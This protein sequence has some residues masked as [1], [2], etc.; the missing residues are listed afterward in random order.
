MPVNKPGLKG[1]VNV[2]RK[3]VAL[4]G[5]SPVTSDFF[6]PEQRLPLVVRPSES[7]LS[8]VGWARPNRE[9]IESRLAEHGAILFRDFGMQTAAD[10]EAFIRALSMEPVQYQEATSPRTHLGGNIYTSTDYP[11]AERI[12]WHN[13]N[14]HASSWPLH[15]FF[16]CETPATQG[17]ETPIADS[18]KIY[19][20]I[21]EPLRERFA[22]K[23][24]MY[25]RNFGDGLGLPWQSVFHTTERKEVDDH[26][27]A[28]GIITEW[29]DETRLRIRYVRPAVAAHPQTGDVVWFN[30]VLLFHISRREQ[31]VREA[32]LATYRQEDLPYNVFY[33]DGSPIDDADVNAIHEIYRRESALF[34]WQAG[35][36]LMLDNMLCAHG[37]EPYA[38][39][40]KILVGMADPVT[41][42]SI[43]N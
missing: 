12:L 24:L 41:S 3:A 35:D 33:G 37:R 6:R 11:P 43:T 26:C 4:S 20:G 10:L 1:L 40:R 8:L 36:I 14:S 23:Q 7:G 17:G 30:H 18:R 42:S 19:R 38:G 21:N 28:R 13:E 2:R 9:F 39:A 27:R 32:L 31:A 16:F 29:K 34:S 25:V 22:D 15:I 5:E